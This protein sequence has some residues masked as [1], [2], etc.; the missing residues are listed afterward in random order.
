MLLRAS[1]VPLLPRA[2]R[3]APMS[4]GRTRTF[5]VGQGGRLVVDMARAAAIFKV[6]TK[7]ID[8]CDVSVSR[9]PAG[10]DVSNFEKF[11]ART[12]SSDDA[13]NLTLHAD[14]ALAQVTI[15]HDQER[16]GGDQEG[17]YLVEA[18]VPELFSVDVLLSHGN[19][20]V[21]KKLKGDCQVQLDKGDI[22]V[23]TVRGETIRLS[24]GCGDVKVDELEGNVHIEA[25]ADVS[26]ERHSAVAFQQ[27]GFKGFFYHGIL[28]DIPVGINYFGYS[29]S[30]SSHVLFCCG[31]ASRGC[32]K[33]VE[34]TSP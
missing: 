11:G 4:S 33:S 27:D 9:L 28:Q 22:S 14:E 1:M 26:L 19:V 6:T 17:M 31:C 21:A 10:A 15:A 30:Q 25:T 2:A 13:T 5:E 16:M 23:G 8:S 7:W 24:T 12:E 34:A 29:S 20:S 32:R 3:A 18:V